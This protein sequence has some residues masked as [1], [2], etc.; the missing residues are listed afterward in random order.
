MTP[1]NLKFGN[2]YLPRF[3]ILTYT[4]QVRYVIV[5]NNNTYYT[6]NF[7]CEYPYDRV[8]FNFRLP[9][10]QARRNRGAG[11]GNGPSWFWRRIESNLSFSH[12]TYLDFYWSTLIFRPSYGPPLSV[13][14]VL[15]RY[16]YK[17][18]W[19]KCYIFSLKI[20]GVGSNVGLSKNLVGAMQ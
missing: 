10:L 16:V 5:A 20:E 19:I 9:S 3:K 6:L 17:L 7:F 12:G 4:L 11:V 15:K 8:W 1:Q 14:V 13:V 2:E 18:H